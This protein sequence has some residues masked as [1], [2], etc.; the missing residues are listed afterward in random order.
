MNGDKEKRFIDL[1][2]HFAIER[3]AIERRHSERIAPLVAERDVALQINLD[4]WNRTMRTARV[5]N[6]I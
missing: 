4:N 1:N 2:D 3:E 5:N 6:K